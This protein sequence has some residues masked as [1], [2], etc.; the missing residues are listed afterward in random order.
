MKQVL[1]SGIAVIVCAHGA[2]AAPSPGVSFSLLGDLEGGSFFSVANAVS[3]DGL[4]VVGSSGSSNGGE[5]F[6]WRA[7][8]GMVGI[9]DLA[10]GPFDS[11]AS[12]VSHDGSVVVGIGRISTGGPGVTGRAF[13][14]ESGVGMTDLGTINGSKNGFSNAH[15]VSRDGRFV[16]GTA[17][18]TSGFDMFRWDGDSGMITAGGF[19]GRGVTDDGSMVVGFEVIGGGAFEAQRWTSETGPVGLGF[20][21]GETGDSRANAVSP[22]GRFI[23]G[24]SSSAAAGAGNRE[25]FLW[26][27]SGGMVGL[28]STTPG[29]GDFFTEALATNIDA[30][31]IVGYEQIVGDDEFIA[32]VWTEATGMMRL[33]GLLEDLGVDLSGVSLLQARGVSADGRTIVGMAEDEE[34]FRIGFIA[35]IPAPASAVMLMA[36]GYEWRRRRR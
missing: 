21:S 6:V 23:I 14:W 5:A 13:R 33:D 11:G 10:T 24:S 36:F 30:S 34:G 19:E 22:D 4:T 27:E 16:V 29:G 1:Q 20:L 2:L 26:S 18:N 25:A 12:G 28:G 31:V 9:G 15:A 35:T 32:T 17:Q 8:T 3:G 7:D